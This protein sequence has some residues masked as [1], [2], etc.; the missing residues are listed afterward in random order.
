MKNAYA[1]AL[2]VLVALLLRRVDVFEIPRL[3]AED[4][5]VFFAD[6][7]AFGPIATLFRPYAG[8]LHLVPRI[9]ADLG[10]G[11]PIAWVPRFYVTVAFILDTACCSLFALPIFRFL[12][13]SDGMRA[14]VC[15]L[16]A[17]APGAN[18]LIGNVANLQWYLVLPV[19]LVIALPAEM[20]RNWKPWR[21]AATSVAGFLAVASAPECLIALPI[22]VAKLRDRFGLGRPIAVAFLVASALQI[23]AFGHATHTTAS[24]AGARA[25]ALGFVTAAALRGVVVPL[26]GPWCAQ[27]LSLDHTVLTS[28][29]ILVALAALFTPFV[30][31][32]SADNR[33]HV[34]TIVYFAAASMLLALTLR[35]FTL[36][37]LLHRP[38]IN[39]HDSE[40]YFS[41]AEF[42]FIFTVAM[43]VGTL[44]ATRATRRA[45][46]LLA[47]FSP[48]I[49]ANFHGR[50]FSARVPDWQP[51][52]ARVAAWEIASRRDPAQ[53]PRLALPIAPEGWTLR[54]PPLPTN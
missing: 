16:L 23:S 43:C 34:G 38:G 54:L 2:A 33:L 1:V 20:T 49:I 50:P 28:V 11:L 27:W 41:T 6:V 53:P 29:A 21:V 37:M 14:V 40:R 26:A 44:Q 51:D 19:F 47:I 8:Y 13:R 15:V 12:L 42:A 25:L 45:V 3:W 9:I 18:E 36:T 5:N 24:H 46:L 52:A 35:G 48:G 17:L 10:S 30:N 7:V 39:A 32:L 31:R 22:V 4:G